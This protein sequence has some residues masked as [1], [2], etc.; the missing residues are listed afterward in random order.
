MVRG[1]YPKAVLE[2][3]LNGA[4]GTGSEV[5]RELTANSTNLSQIL[6]GQWL[7]AR[8]NLA[9]RP[10]ER[11][12]DKRMAIPCKHPKVRVVS[13][14]EDAEFVECVECG[15]VFDSDEFRDMELEE[16]V[17]QPAEDGPED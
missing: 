16:K 11:N 9:Q 5:F 7:K 15:E 13:R 3:G 17:T 10:A 2:R 1:E 4:S 14:T 12:G 6:L 8:Y